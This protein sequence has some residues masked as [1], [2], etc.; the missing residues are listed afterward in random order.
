MEI[1]LLYQYCIVSVM[2]ILLGNFL[3]NNHLFK[4]TSRFTLPTYIKKKPP[5]VSILIP[6][7]NEERNIRRCLRSLARQDYPNFEIIVLDDNSSDN[8]GSIV[9]EIS[10]K[11]PRIR[12]IKGE[13]LESGWLGKSFACHQLSKAANGDYLLFTDADTLH[14]KNS[15][16]SALSSLLINKLDAISVFARQI[17]VTLHERMMVPFANYFLLTFF[18]LILVAKT[19]NPL[20]CTAIGQFMLFKR[21]V[22]KKIGGHE[23][24]KKEILEDIHISKQVKKHGYKFMIFDGK[25]N[26]YC[27]MYKN[28]KEVING[29]SKVLAAVFDYNIFIQSL[30]TILVFLVYL[31]PF[32][33]LPAG[34]FLFHL[35]QMI[36]NLIILHIIIITAIKIIQTIRFKNRFI[37]VL[38]FPVSVIYLLCIS[39]ISI[40]QSKS[41]TGVYWKGRS[42]D[43]RD[44]KELKLLKDGLK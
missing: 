3:I 20:F 36:I 10:A 13:V 5:L 12:L 41:T 28:L 7:R 17:T 42:Y 21:S 6:A 39:I 26:F 1:L 23:S 25:N 29:Y 22:Y 19:K 18:P 33:A 32:I 30:T 24:V 2:V 44:E 16:S 31:V 9:S 35:P 15:L 34:I 11:D 37:D 40:I 43:V 14:F 4:D 8:T 38:L 27:R